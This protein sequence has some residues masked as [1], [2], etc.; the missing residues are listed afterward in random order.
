MGTGT[1]L[2]RHVSLGLA[3]LYCGVAIC[4]VCIFFVRRRGGGGQGTESKQIFPRP[5]AL[6]FPINWC[7]HGVFVRHAT[8]VSAAPAWDYIKV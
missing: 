6:R 2:R 4:S 7:R 3:C 5:A 8:L 1:E